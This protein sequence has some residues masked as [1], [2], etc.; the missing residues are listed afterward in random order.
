MPKPSGL[1]A[2]PRLDALMQSAAVALFVDFD[3]TLVDLAERPTEIVVP[4]HL[5]KRLEL[6]SDRIGGRLAVVSGRANG[7][8]ERYL[9]QLQVARAGSHGLTR[10]LA[11]GASLGT[12]PD[13]FPRA[14]AES[15]QEFAAA[16]RF[17]LEEKPHGA[18]LHYRSAPHLE[19][20]G[21]AFANQLAELHGLKVK[22]GRSVIELVS[23]NADK[24]AAVRA[25]MGV[26]PFAGSLPVFIG[27]DL[28][29]EDGFSAASALGGFGVLVG[30]R[31]P[32]VASYRLVDRAAVHEWLGL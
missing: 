11:N 15:L 14:A 32:T 18:A 13:L 16:Q 8:L 27:D 26:E 23:V 1:D 9:G 7:D 10:A 12:E 4:Q 3:G 6:L 17:L 22:R 28:T 2:P 31:H 25:F 20:G 19:T 21:I 5:G 29:D 30:T 24:G